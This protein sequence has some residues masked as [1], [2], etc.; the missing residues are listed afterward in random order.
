M[1][2]P[3]AVLERE[4]ADTQARARTLFETTSRA[5]DAD[6][7]RAMTVEERGAIQAIADEGL[8]I[9]KLIAEGRAD[10]D[11]LAEIDRL[12]VGTA[13]L[14]ERGSRGRILSIGQQL[15]SNAE[16]NDFI[17][18]QGHRKGSA[19]QS[20]TVEVYRP[21]FQAATLTEDPASGGALVMPQYLPGIHTPPTRPIV[22]ADLLAPGTTTSNM[23]AYMREKTFTNAAAPVLEGGLKPESTLIFEGATDPV[24]KIAHWLPVTEEM[25]EDVPQIRSYID[26]RLIIGVQLVEDDQLLNGDGVA[27]NLLGLRSRAGLAAPIVRVGTETNADA[28]LRQALAIFGS[29]FLMPDGFVLNP[30]DWANTLLTK[31]EAGDY[32]TGGPFSP[33][34]GASLWGLPVAVTPMMEA[35][36]GFVGAFKTAAQIFRRGGIRVEA[37]NSHADF[38]IKNLVAIRAEERLA[39]A[40]YRPGAF[41]EVTS[42]LG[43]AGVLSGGEQSTSPGR[44]R[45]EPSRGESHA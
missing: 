9:K 24:R 34:Q 18:R 27:P 4:L 6:N 29:S 14:P 22:V 12:T 30:A 33:I 25:L 16:W 37:S 44:K 21:D 19:W 8:A 20:P 11:M 3:I 40:V 41:G 39:L 10:G 35:A 28:L 7:N 45:Q 38:F 17:K 5:C 1:K 36:T 32:Y 13:P 43:A 42:L 23:I 15:T 2:K 31:S 26:A